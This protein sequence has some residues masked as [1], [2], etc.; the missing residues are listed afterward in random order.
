MKLIIPILLSCI[1]F[2]ITKTRMRRHGQRNEF[3]V[4][5]IKEHTIFLRYS[6][7]VYNIKHDKIYVFLESQRKRF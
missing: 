5:L 3:Y 4:L 1:K 2:I 6:K 7:H